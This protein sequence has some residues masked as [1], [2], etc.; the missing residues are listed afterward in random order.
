[1][2]A[3]TSLRPEVHCGVRADTLLAV[4]E[5][6]LSPVDKEWHAIVYDLTV[7]DDK[8]ITINSECKMEFILPDGDKK[9]IEGA[10]YID[11]G[12]KGE[13]LL[14]LCEGN[15]CEVCAAPRVGYNCSVHR[16][17]GVLRG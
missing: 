16:P 13:F 5:G 15:F 6:H 2:Y 8:T 10:E 9:G 1:M 3:G 17:A 11:N 12:D 7:N 14:G 4:K